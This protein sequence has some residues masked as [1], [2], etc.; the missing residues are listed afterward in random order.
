MPDRAQALTGQP[1][2]HL[3][4]ALVPQVRLERCQ[5]AEPVTV[6]VC[7]PHPGSG[8]RRATNIFQK[9]FQIAFIN[10]LKNFQTASLKTSD[11]LRAIGRSV[12]KQPVDKQ[13]SFSSMQKKRSGPS[14]R[15]YSVDNASA[16]PHSLKGK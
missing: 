8:G 10:F 13:N 1:A 6:P 16:G 3:R 11:T 15:W 2:G 4:L 7:L 9:N 14:F 12:M 5:R